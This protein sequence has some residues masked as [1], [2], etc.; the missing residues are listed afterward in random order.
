MT[1]S[2]RSPAI[3]RILSELKQLHN[4]PDPHFVANPL[5]D[6]LFEWHF[7]VRGP[8]DTP[9]EGGIYHGRILLPPEYPFKPPSIIFLTPNGRFRVNEKICLSVTGFH[10][11]FWRP[12]WGIRTV[13]LALLSFMPTRAEG[14]VGALEVGDEGRRK[15]ARISPLWTCPQ[16][17]IPNG[18]LLP[19][20][21][22]RPP[23]P[24][25]GGAGAQDGAGAGAG[26]TGGGQGDGSTAKKGSGDAEA[27]AARELISMMRMDYEGESRKEGGEAGDGAAEAAAGQ[28]QQ[29]PSARPTPAAPSTPT[30]ESATSVPSPSPAA[31]VT[32]HAGPAQTSTSQPP[33]AHTASAPAPARPV[34]VPAPAPTPTLPPQPPTRPSPSSGPSPGLRPETELVILDVLIAAV[35][36]ALGVLV[37]R[38]AV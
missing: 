29:G 20:L 6:N 27:E 21:P 3:K 30:P 15:E 9:F 1:S 14:A 2:S 28:Q 10:P 36:A 12:A 25:A 19:P 4:E 22:P 38:V 34:P 35:V 33:R 16:C 26:A 23:P 24:A 32:A 18:T 11:E 8:V 7:T 13:L 17:K 5:D 37:V 31:G